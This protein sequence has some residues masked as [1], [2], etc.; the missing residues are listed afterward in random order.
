MPPEAWP[1]NLSK[2]VAISPNKLPRVLNNVY[3]AEMLTPI[4]QP[5]DKLDDLTA[6]EMYVCLFV[7]TNLN[8]TLCPL[9][10]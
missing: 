5:L 9:P 6:E 1:S 4:D 8:L 3:I 2:Q 7:V 10:Q